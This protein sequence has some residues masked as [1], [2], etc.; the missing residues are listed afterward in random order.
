MPLSRKIVDAPVGLPILVGNVDRQH[1]HLGEVAACDA[2][3]ITA[4]LYGWTAV[5]TGT[6]QTVAE[7]KAAAYENA[8]KVQTPNLRYRGDIGDALINGELERLSKC[9]WLKSS[10]PTRMASQ[11]VL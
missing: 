1:L 2:K 11:M 8:G 3:L 6:G 10:P 7:A 4:G 5:V 9:G